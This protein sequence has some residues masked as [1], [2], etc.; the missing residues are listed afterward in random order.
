MGP[1]GG[2]GS[3]VLKSFDIHGSAFLVFVAAMT[4][5][6]PLAIDMALP[7]L[8]LVEADFG[9]SRTLAATSIAIFLA[10]FSTAP[11]LVG[12]L[13]DRFGRKPALIGGLLLFTL[14]GLGAAF[15]PSI[16][17]LVGLRS[18]RAP[19]PAPS[20]SCRARSCA[21]SSTSTNRASSSR[22]SPR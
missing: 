3:L 11:L 9:A 16:L 14:S 19:A 21:T 17:A 2:R 8:A 12:P 22:R 10:G 15:A 1:G 6:P 13:A 20:A 4:A 18:S 7:S 5:L